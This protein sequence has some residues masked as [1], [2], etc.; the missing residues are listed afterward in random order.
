[1]LALPRCPRHRLAGDLWKRFST[2]LYC[3][4]S[5]FLNGYCHIEVLLIIKYLMNYG[6]LV[7]T[8]YFPHDIA[9]RPRACLIR[10]AEIDN[11]WKHWAVDNQSYGKTLVG[12]GSNPEPTD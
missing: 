10:S 8:Q 12:W 3:V 11:A 7:R 1:M 2:F 9:I 4:I 6:I 5:A